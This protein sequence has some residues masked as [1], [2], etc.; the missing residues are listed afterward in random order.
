[1]EQVTIEC[2][3]R[4]DLGKNGSRRLRREGWVP[5]IVYGTDEAPLPIA[6]ERKMMDRLLHQPGG[7][8]TVY[9][10]QLGEK[11]AREVLVKDLQLHPVRNTLT[12]LDFLAVSA[13]LPV[14][15]KVTI[16]LTGVPIGVKNMGGL[17][18]TLVRS[19]RVQC[20]A[21]DI[22]PA[23]TVDVSGLELNQTIKVRDLPVSDR[24]RVLMDPDVNV[25]HVVETRASAAKAASVVEATKTQASGKKA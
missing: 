12:H 3:K 5:A 9:R 22:P 15:V 23:I 20:L 25:A 11:E 17:L 18:E 13:S 6:V 19:V 8:N 16:E 4:R 10:L 1:M 14:E 24:I 21:R 7:R 2:R